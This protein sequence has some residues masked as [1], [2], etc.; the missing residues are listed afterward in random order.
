M[1]LLKYSTTVQFT[2]NPSQDN[3]GSTI[4]KRSF[5]VHVT[6]GKEDIVKGTDIYWKFCTLCLFPWD[7]HFT[8]FSLFLKIALKQQAILGNPNHQLYR[9]Q[10]HCFQDAVQIILFVNIQEKCSMNSLSSKCPSIFFTQVTQV[11]LFSSA[12]KIFYL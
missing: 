5:T 12:H 6:A 4:T 3:G 11:K 9:E 8:T 10:R 1:C 7:A 2:M